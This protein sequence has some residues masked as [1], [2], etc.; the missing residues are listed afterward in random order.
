[1]SRYLQPVSNAAAKICG[2]K[3]GSVALTT[4]SAPAARTQ[5]AIAFCDDASSCTAEK[6]PSSRRSTTASARSGSRSAKVRCSKND[7]RCATAAIAD[8]T[9][10]VPITRTFT[11]RGESHVSTS[12]CK[13]DP[14]HCDAHDRPGLTE[15]VAHGTN[16]L[17]LRR[18]AV[19][20][21]QAVVDGRRGAVSTPRR[22]DAL[23]QGIIEALQANG[24]ESFRAIASR[25][26]VSEATVRARYARLCAD[27]ILQVVGVR[28]EEHTSEL[29]SRQ[30]LVCRLL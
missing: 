5:P 4:T 6:R 3:R 10:P 14:A 29:Q 19:Q 2:L 15:C 1:M 18:A 12:H 9:P 24:R 20:P 7:R 13:P 17:A 25:L 22:I 21:G 27:N 28:S 26:G 8:P 30:Y 23:D 16:R 11:R